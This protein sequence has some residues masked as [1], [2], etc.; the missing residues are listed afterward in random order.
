MRYLVGLLAVAGIAG[1]TA[2]VA[3][4]EAAADPFPLKF[5]GYATAS[6]TWSSGAVGDQI[7]GRFYDRNQSEF[8]ANALKLVIEK[9]FDSA[10][11]SGGFKFDALF[12]QNAEVTGFAGNRLALGEQGDLLQAYA[13]VNVPTG[14][15]TWVQFTAG[16]FAT[17]IGAEVMEDVV[18]PNLSIGNQFVY[19][20]NFTNTGLKV[21]AKFS[22]KV[23]AQ[24]SIS[25]G[26]DLV[27][28]NNTGKSVMGR[29]GYSPTGTTTVA[30]IGYFGPEQAGSGNKRKGAEITVLT[31]LGATT[32][33]WLEGDIGEEE[34]LTNGGLD[35]ATWAGI[36][37]WLVQDLSPTAS[38]ALR[39]DYVSD[40][41][42]VRTSGLFGFPTNSGLKFGN[43]TATL[44]LKG[45]PSVLIRPEVRV[46]FANLAVFDSSKAQV[47]FALGTSFLF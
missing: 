9:P 12:G 36:G 31:K 11:L 2:P 23:D 33:L 18:N 42:G 39:G 34:G 20:E 47:S 22:P 28:D 15:D 16:K 27:R 7:V 5:S 32:A 46:D 38:L 41:D 4:Q 30:L 14:K 21:A 43:A 1:V 13:I 29:V 26:W 6:Y 45:I 19:L 35:K 24:L 8:M 3:A 40:K 25:N 17:L 44:N 10:K 37:A